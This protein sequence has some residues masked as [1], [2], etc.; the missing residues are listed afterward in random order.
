MSTTDRST[1]ANA[2]QSPTSEQTNTTGFE[3]TQLAL[4]Y[5]EVDRTATVSSAP[6]D[7]LSVPATEWI[8]VDQSDLVD[9]RE[10]R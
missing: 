4:T 1:D 10:H 8:T 7:E 6:P 5:N 9:V 3:R 2:S